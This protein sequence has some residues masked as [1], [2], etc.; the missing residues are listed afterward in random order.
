MKNFL[1][2]LAT[3]LTLWVVVNGQGSSRALKDHLE[4]GVDDV[5]LIDN[6]EVLP[7]YNYLAQ[8]GVLKINEPF[9]CWYHRVSDQ[10]WLLTP[11]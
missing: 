11:H 8:D 10:G 5:V 4:F 7:R 6:I 3:E 9:Y 2:L 1:D